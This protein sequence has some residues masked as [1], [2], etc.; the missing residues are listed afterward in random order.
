L[1]FVLITSDDTVTLKSEQL[2]DILILG[3]V[4]RAQEVYFTSCTQVSDGASVADP[5]IKG[6]YINRILLSKDVAISSDTGLVCPSNCRTCSEDNVCLECNGGNLLYKGSCHASC[7]E[8]D[9]YEYGSPFFMCSP[10]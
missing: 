3:K 6:F 1:E 5:T 7:E 4:I 2:I 9:S 8:E 10:Q